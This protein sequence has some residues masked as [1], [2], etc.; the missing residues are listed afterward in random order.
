ME[1]RF[2][3]LCIRRSLNPD[4]VEFQNTQC[5]FAE[6]IQIAALVFLKQQP[7]NILG[8]EGYLDA[9]EPAFLDDTLLYTMSTSGSVPVV[10]ALTLISLYGKQS[11]YLLFLSTAVLGLSTATLV[12][13]MVWW[14][15]FLNINNPGGSI[16]P[17]N[18]G[19]PSG[20]TDPVTECVDYSVLDLKDLWCGTAQT[21]A[22]KIN[23]ATLAISAWVWVI[24]FIC[25]FWTSY[26]LI[27]HATDCAP[28]KSRTANLAIIWHD[29]LF[30]KILNRV[31]RFMF[32]AT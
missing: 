3:E 21:L 30:G 9:T 19:G 1:S 26:C 16:I 2:E 8:L 32:V 4:I 27:K 28:M 29:V 10:F 14:Q 12:C 22:D 15:P 5:Y 31:W 23:V 11:W 18:I 17:I 6:A 20:D 7:Q 24:Y 13:S 25:A